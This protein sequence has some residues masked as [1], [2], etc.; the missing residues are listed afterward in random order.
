MRE[1]R[2][3]IKVPRQYDT[4]SDNSEKDA[5]EARADSVSTIS[6]AV[7]PESATDSGATTMKRVSV[8]IAAIAIVA[9]ACSSASD[10]SR[11]AEATTT[12]ASS[13]ATT[14]VEPTTTTT[15]ADLTTTTLR[16]PTT[17]SAFAPASDEDA[18]EITALYEIVF[19]SET[20]YEEKAPLIDDPSGLEETVAKYT[21]TGE[22]L[23]GV[24]LV[25]KTITVGGDLASVTYDLL[26]SGNPTY[27]DLT[28]DAI[29]VDGA[30]LVTREMFCS[31]MTSARVGCPSS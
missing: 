29:R 9:T 6:G 11:I 17:T 16:T 19:S 21:E 7:L 31:I 5:S 28:G 18:A 24:G 10:A 30:W 27:P 22:T 12:S 8:L 1:V 2:V 13:V 4:N 25:A 15:T 23:G 3:T 26:F 14:M 20:T